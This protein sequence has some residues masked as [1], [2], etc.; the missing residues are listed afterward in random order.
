M[1]YNISIRS[2]ERNS[3][4]QSR[5]TR[6]IVARLEREGW[7]KRAGKGDH[8]NFFKPNN[9]NL[10]TIDMGRKEVGKRALKEIGKKAGWE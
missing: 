3:M 4:E 7:L 8:V 10:I 2:G 9:P 5:D 6:K 1:I